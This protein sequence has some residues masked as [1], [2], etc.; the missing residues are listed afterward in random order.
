M[1]RDGYLPDDVSEA[2]YDRAFPSNDCPETCPNGEDWEPR[3]CGECEEKIAECVCWLY[4]VPHTWN[5]MYWFIWKNVPGHGWDYVAPW[6]RWLDPRC[7]VY[8]VGY[9]LS[10]LMRRFEWTHGFM[11]DSTTPEKPGECNCPNADEV[12]A[13]RAEARAGAQEDR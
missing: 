1:S 8:A 13:E 4:F 6:Y 10:E 12:A 7:Y 9:R 3:E 5:R 2:D 11:G